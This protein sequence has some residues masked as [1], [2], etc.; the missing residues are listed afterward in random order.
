MKLILPDYNIK[1]EDG[2]AEVKD[3]ILY[4]Y[5]PGSF[6]EVMYQLTYLIYGK[7]ECYFCHKKLRSNMLEMDNEKYF[8]QITLDHLIPQEFGGP[9]ITNNLRPACSE[10]NSTK[11]NMYPEE[12]L[13]Y[14]NFDNNKRDK[15]TKIAKRSFKEALRFTQEQ[16][17]YGVIESIDKEWFTDESIRNIYVSFWIAEPLGLM[18]KKQERFFKK[19]KRL[20][21]PIVV[22]QN[23][24]L[25]DGFNTILLAKYNY[26]ERLS[27][28]VLENVI[29]VGFP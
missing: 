12:F 7:D 24:F 17:R 16:R 26:C 11:G 14:R 19:Y 15:K 10:C 5:K 3:G 4:I 29:F 21:K 18:Y 23:R 25:L 28:I 13:K 6:K 20:P 8:S 22:S 27:I 2:L 1:L 9:T